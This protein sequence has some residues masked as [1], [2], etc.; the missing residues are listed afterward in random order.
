MK[1]FKVFNTE[2]E[3]LE[4]ISSDKFIAPNI[5]TLYDSTKTWILEDREVI[6]VT[7]VTLNESSISI[8]KDNTFELEATVTPNDATDK[9]VTWSSSDATIATVDSNGVVSGVASGDATITVTTVD[10]GFTAQCSVSVSNHDYSH[11]Y[12]TLDVLT[13]GTINWTSRS[14]VTKTISYSKDN[15]STWTEITSTATGTPINVSAGDKVLLKG[16]NDQYAT[17]R[18]AGSTFGD[19]GMASSN[20]AYYNVQGN[21]MSLVAGDNFTGATTL[22]SGYTFHSLFDYARV[23]SAENLVLPATTLSNYCYRALLANCSSLTVAPELPA[24]TLAEGC[25]YAMF[26]GCSNIETAPT[27]L[28]ET[29]P[30]SA[31]T[32]MFYLC[33]NLNYIKCLAIDKSASGCLYLWV[34]D[35]AASGI[36]IKSSATTWSS[37]ANGIPNGWT[38]FDEGV[39]VS[40]ITVNPST[41]VIKKDET[42]SLVPTT[43]PNNAYN[44]VTWSS[45]DRDIVTVDSNGFVSGVSSGDAVIT[46]TAVN[47]GL[48]AQCAVKVYQT[49][50]T[51]LEYIA[52]TSSGGQYIDLNIMLYDELNKW[53]DIAIKFNAIRAGKDGDAQSTIFGCQDNTGSPWPGTFIRKNTSNNNMVG[54]YIGGIAKDNTLGQMGNDIELS[55]KDAPN[56]NV[57]DLNNSNK[58]H[59]WGTSLFCIFNNQ[60]KTAMIRYIEAKLYYF[61]LYLKADKTSQG[62]IVRDLIPCRRNSDNAIGLLDKV[63][64]VFYLSPNGVAFVAGPEVNA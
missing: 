63:N 37:G 32:Y 46:V 8:A 33:S 18:G 45:S 14:G 55:P 13:G 2:N 25:Y 53:Y 24:T 39:T 22:S 31:Y 42:Y 49:E 60:A 26:N 51:E 62:F 6:H 19:S 48:T 57:Y 36:F 47:G 7:S 29:I 12:L 40:S 44:R 21:I 28:A 30:T 58:T 1:Y 11:D 35:V 54:R 56:M 41:L 64:N 43:K 61:K 5:S 50:Y 23:V 38:V 59:T 52:S 15:G 3:Y 10:G 9:S 34:G 4:Y 27:L 20:T 16:T 17:G